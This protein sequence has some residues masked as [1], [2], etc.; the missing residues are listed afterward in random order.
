MEG[1]RG[2]F[3]GFPHRLHHTLNLVFLWMK[4]GRVLSFSRGQEGFDICEEKKGGRDFGEDFSL[5]FES[6]KYN[7]IF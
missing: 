5:F 4:K 3:I 2:G 1:E 7:Y 6:P